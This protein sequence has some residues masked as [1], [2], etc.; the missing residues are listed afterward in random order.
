MF[1][2]ELVP[3]L[4]ICDY[5]ILDT[6]YFDTR[7]IGLYIHIY[8]FKHNIKPNINS[9]QQYVEIKIKDINNDT[10]QS[11][12][13]MIQ[14]QNIRYAKEFADYIFKYYKYIQNSL[15]NMRGVV[16]YSK[17]GIQKAATMAAGYL[18]IRCKIDTQTSINIMNSKEPLF[19]KNMVNLHTNRY[20][21][22]NE[23]LYEHTLKYIETFI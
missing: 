17:H 15:Q 14:R 11:S 23:P 6:A 1:V 5:D 21:I 22:D 3:N 7:N 13:Q 9:N 2:S 8:T 19:F 18:I 10:Y 20:N 4:W 16:I 12:N